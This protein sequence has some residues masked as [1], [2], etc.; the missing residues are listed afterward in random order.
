[1]GLTKIL[2]DEHRVIE[3]VL[4][5]LSKITQEANNNGKLDEA[6][7]NQAIDI[8]RTFAD[9]CHHGKEEDHLFAAMVEK[10]MPKEGGP[11]GQMLV[12][13]EQGRAFVKEMA[14]NVSE[15]AQGIS[16]ALSKFTQNAHGYV[17]LLRAHIQ[18]EDGVLFPMADKV[19]NEDDQKTLMKAFEAVESDHMGTGTHEKY[20]GIVVSLAKK[21][22]VEASHI[23]SHSCGCGH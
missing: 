9:K 22:G 20:I 15:A 13:H 5:C 21:Y 16:D 12:E 1:M 4:S 14:D 7:A 10:G 3:V 18:K 19:L 23:S 8:I 6:S 17:Q 11:V 2:S